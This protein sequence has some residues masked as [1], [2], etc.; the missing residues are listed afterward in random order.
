MILKEKELYDW[1]KYLKIDHSYKKSKSYPFSALT[2]YELYIAFPIDLVLKWNIHSNGEVRSLYISSNN[3]YTLIEYVSTNKKILLKSNLNYFHE[4]NIRQ[5]SV[6]KEFELFLS[7]VD[8]I[9][10]R[11]I[12]RDKKINKLLDE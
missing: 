6:I 1:F 4:R 11:D 8:P 2:T 3:I 7:E 5:S 12:I 10:F 9:Y